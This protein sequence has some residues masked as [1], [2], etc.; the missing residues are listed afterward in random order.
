MTRVS[1]VYSTPLHLEMPIDLAGPPLRHKMV[2]H[3]LEVFRMKNLG[4]LVGSKFWSKSA[5]MFNGGS[6]L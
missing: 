1:G 5:S 6:M 2:G 3:L 4:M